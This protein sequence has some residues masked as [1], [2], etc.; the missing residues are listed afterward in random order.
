MNSLDIGKKYVD[1]L[2]LINGNINNTIIDITNN[3]YQLKTTLVNVD[4]RYRNKMSSNIV[5]MYTDNLPNNAIETT[6]NSN[7]VKIN[8]IG[9]NYNMGDQIILQNVRGKKLILNKSITLLKNSCYF[10]VY[11]NNHNITTNAYYKIN[12]MKYDSNNINNYGNVMVNS[13]IGIHDIEIYDPSLHDI[14]SLDIYNI[15]NNNINNNY[16]FIKLP[17]ICND[18]IY[19]DTIFEFEIMNIGGIPLQYLNANY[20]INYN[21]FQS[22]HEI[23]SV[24]NN[25][26]YFVSSYKAITSEIGG[27]DNISLGKVINTNEG[28]PDPSYYVYKLKTTFNNVVQIE[29]VSSEIPYCDINI[30][31][32]NNKLYWKYLEDGDYIYSITIAEGNYCRESLINY[33]LYNMN[34]IKRINNEYN[35]S[36]NIDINSNTNEVQF[37]AFTWNDEVRQP[38]SAS[39]LFNTNDSIGDI[40]GFRYCGEAC[41]I[42]PFL[43]V[44]SNMNQYIMNT[45]SF[46]TSINTFY[47]NNNY[48]FLYINDYEN[49]LTNPNMMNCFTKISIYKKWDNVMF[50]T[51]VKY[52][53]LIFLSPQS[54][55]SEF[56][57]QFLLPDGNRPNF[58]GM[59]HSFTLKITEIITQCYNTGLNS[60]NSN[61]TETISKLSM[62]H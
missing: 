17:Y 28:Y 44:N 2:K 50:N 14:S 46:D 5:S 38:T 10:M 13:I 40:L 58:R 27:G 7:I 20:P 55:I 19:C 61:Y 21:N 24:E 36:F 25:A 49:M 23:I 1:Q 43:H 54:C 9:H 53:P 60:K 47:N 59:D 34:N 18:T 57:V 4:S 31:C 6:T 45:L 15:N 29:I 12:I 3:N 42:T 22:S 35:V 48:L 32:K 52:C 30:N 11:I 41:A 16:F 39:F 8:M 26:I 33:M 62:N 37:M 56:K 51:F